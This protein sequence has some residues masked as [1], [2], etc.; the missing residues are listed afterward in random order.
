MDD[1]GFSWTILQFLRKEEK[2]ELR[3][4]SERLEVEHLNAA[5]VGDTVQ[6][7]QCSLHEPCPA[8]AVEIYHEY[9]QRSSH[10]IRQQP[11][12]EKSCPPMA[13]FEL[14]ITSSPLLRASISEPLLE[15]SPEFFVPA[16]A[17]RHFEAEYW[18]GEHDERGW[19]SS[20]DDD[21][22]DFEQ[23]SSGD[24]K[25]Q[26]LVA[27]SEMDDDN[28]QQ[29]PYVHRC[30]PSGAVVQGLFNGWPV[31]GELT[32]RLRPYDSGRFV[33]P[34]FSEKLYEAE[35]WSGQHGE[36]LSDDEPRDVDQRAIV[37][38]QGLFA[39]VPVI[40]CCLPTVSLSNFIDTE[41]YS[42]NTDVETSQETETL[43]EG[44][45]EDGHLVSTKKIMRVVTTTRTLSEDRHRSNDLW[46]RRKQLSKGKKRIFII[47]AHAIGVVEHECSVVRTHTTLCFE[48]TSILNRTAS[49]DDCA[50]SAGHVR[51]IKID[52]SRRQRT[53]LRAY[54]CTYILCR[55]RRRLLI[56]IYS[57]SFVC[58]VVVLWSSG[59]ATKLFGKV[60]TRGKVH[61]EK[62]HLKHIRELISQRAMH[63]NIVKGPDGKPIQKTV[64]T[65]Q[66]FGDTPTGEPIV[67]EIS[68]S[69]GE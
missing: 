36:C 27:S 62:I 42:R 56:S 40:H 2:N 28:E 39:G 63:C 54:V 48:R 26:L 30:T 60:C 37:V 15:R 47:D 8:G 32:T 41:D 5:G 58:S 13:N 23:S 14:I 7:G 12:E 16:S 31:L 55:R 6:H 35:H 18:S 64:T 66:T 1:V 65:T 49:I 34:G 4:V 69:P 25:F 17:V 44:Y 67:E 10:L 29:P 22:D 21:R 51:G 45:V 19:S 11:L 43:E 20:E 59:S 61:F 68:S 50:L 52:P 33:E 46:S 38:Q 9:E 3:S 57:R 24:G 53:Y